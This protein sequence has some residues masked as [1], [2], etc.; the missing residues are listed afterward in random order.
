MR[1]IRWREIYER[2]VTEKSTPLAKSGWSPECDHKRYFLSAVAPLLQSLNQENSW[3]DFGCGTGGT[4]QILRDAGVDN[5]AGCDMLPSAVEIA[6]SR[7][8]EADLHV[9]SI[10]DCAPW[11]DE[12][13]DCGICFG[14][15]L[16]LNTHDELS[17]ACLEM[18]R[19]TR[20]GGCV[21]IGDIPDADLE[22]EILERRTRESLGLRDS[23]GTEMTDHL[24]TPTSFFNEFAHAYGCTL[25]LLKRDTSLP[26]PLS[27]RYHVILQKALPSL[28]TCYHGGSFFEAIGNTFDSLEKR[29]DIINADVLDAWFAPSPNI[30]ERLR[31][32]AHLAWLLRTSPPNHCEGLVDTI[33]TSRGVH[34]QSVFAH[35]GSSSIIFAGLQ[36]LLSKKSKVFCVQPTYGEYLHLF[37]QLSCDVQVLQTDWNQGAEEAQLRAEIKQGRPSFV[38]LVNPNSPTGTFLPH[39]SLMRIIKGAPETFFWVDE[40][41]IDFYNP[42]ETLERDAAN[43]NNL[44]VCKSMSKAYALSGMRVAYAITSPTLAMRLAQARPPWALSTLAQIAGIEALRDKDYYVQRWE[45]TRKLCQQ[46]RASLTLLGLEVGPGLANFLMVRLPIAWQVRAS[47]VVE[48]CQTSGLFLRKVASMG[49]CDPQVLRIA[50]K[51]KATNERMIEI[52]SEHLQRLRHGFPQRVFVDGCFDLCHAGH[53]ALISKAL[54]LGDE[55]VVGVNTD[56]L[57]Q[58]YKGRP[59]VMPCDL[60][61]KCMKGLPGVSEVIACTSL[62]VT[63]A[64]LKEHNIHK[65]VHGDDLDLEIAQ[66]WYGDAMEA[67]MYVQV[68]YMQG[69]STTEIMQHFKAWMKA[70]E[71]Q[72][73][74]QLS[75]ESVP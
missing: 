27:H 57:I 70:Q 46:L 29:H 16:Y 43:V 36:H 2:L 6:Q 65:V 49:C 32:P 64:F 25:T 59:P 19:V 72:G 39:D 31:D 41:Y 33:A 61:M 66:E 60:R 54:Q 42:Q 1:S 8:P 18:L 55:V 30:I 71:G 21:M 28:K 51:D 12:S 9:G 69:I 56:A 11:Q 3:V 53:V 14:V 73:N 20:P 75:S 7:F 37:K 58:S 62:T 63:K 26:F 23:N 67:G 45:E 52:L 22:A 13:F 40:T 5:L 15:V 24:F 44:L 38:L 35:A 48:A 74:G 10:C 34:P 4:L 50:V 68:S 17:R 47:D